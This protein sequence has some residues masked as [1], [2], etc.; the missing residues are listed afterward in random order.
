MIDFTLLFVISSI[1]GIGSF[2]G[3]I[4]GKLAGLHPETHTNIR[5]TVGLFHTGTN[6]GED[7]GGDP[8]VVR[9]FDEDGQKISGS[10]G[11]SSPHW[12][13]SKVAVGQYKDIQVTM[14]EDY[15]HRQPLY[16]TFEARG[17]GLCIAVIGMTTTAE[18]SPEPRREN[19]RKITNA[20]PL[21]QPEWGWSGDW[22]KACGGAWY[23]SNI[24]ATKEG[25][26][27]NCVWI[28]RNNDT[29]PYGAIQQ[30]GFQ[31]HF[32]EFRASSRNNTVPE[33]KEE[34]DQMVSY[35]CNSGKPF[36]FHT[37][38]GGFD[39]V[40][41]WVP[42]IHENDPR[43][44]ASYPRV[45]P[46]VIL[47]TSPVPVLNGLLAFP[48]A[49]VTDHSAASPAKA[50][51]DHPMSYGP[52]YKDTY[53]KPIPVPILKSSL[54]LMNR[55]VINGRMTR[56]TSSYARF[57]DWGGHDSLLVNR[58]HANETFSN[59]ALA[60]DVKILPRWEGH[61]AQFCNDDKCEGPC[62]ISVQVQNP[63]CLEQPPR[64]SIK[65]HTTDHRWQWNQDI[66]PFTRLKVHPHH[67]CDCI[68]G[69]VHLPKMEEHH[70]TCMNITNL[71]GESYS[72]YHAKDD[73]FELKPDCCLP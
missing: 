32:S 23:Y 27:P 18:D 15:K 6:C 10:S 1:I 64:K 37:R 24:V 16:A 38:S 45:D 3:H 41:A 51:C 72:F 60:N 19:S 35:I 34:Q 5:V 12:K 67:G 29:M 62:G 25:Y 69:T 21:R 52:D 11:S 30:K 57:H 59:E 54:L 42:P 43:Y 9:L 7:S 56:D 31:I 36:K 48:R 28:D 17:D 13:R 73:V 71:P 66:V 61:W 4:I 68:A 26:K 8:P 47:S 14:H 46:S 70:H 20:A 49:L 53:A 40:D 44:N 55:T 22:G 2:L 58:A 63:G 33:K 39:S 65:F 50:L